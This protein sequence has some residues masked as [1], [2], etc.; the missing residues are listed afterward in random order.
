MNI[1]QNLVIHQPIHHVFACVRDVH[2]AS[3][4]SGLISASEPFD[5]AECEPGVGYRYTSRVKLLN[6]QW[7]VTYQIVECEPNRRITAKTTTGWLPGL[8][9]YCLEPHGQATR[10]TYQHIC[11]LTLMFQPFET[12]VHATLQRQTAIDLANLKDWLESG[13]YQQACQSLRA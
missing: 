2:H 1:T 12:V 10:L 4:W 8:V 11:D 7:D 5:L 9:M 6:R 13:L 3:L